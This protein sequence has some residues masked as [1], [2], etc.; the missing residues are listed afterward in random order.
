MTPGE[1]SKLVHDPDRLEQLSPQH[2]KMDLEGNPYRP[3]NIYLI[4]A[5]FNRAD[6]MIGDEIAVYDGERCVGISV[7]DKELN[8]NQPLQLIAHADDG[9]GSGFTDGDMMSY[10][11][12]RGSSGKE[13]VIDA[14]HVTYFDPVSGDRISGPGFASF[15][16]AVISFNVSSVSGVDDMIVPE[17]YYLYQN[18]PN[19][20]NPST[21]IKY[22][23]PV[24]SEV[25][26]E[27]YGVG[28]NFV[29]LI[30]QGNQAAGRHTVLWDGTNNRGIKVVSGVYF[31]K[32]TAGQFVD[33][34]K[35]ILAK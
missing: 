21:R 15:G 31:Y 9:S 2:F 35:M 19:P 4:G 18:H 34:K 8:R 7:L 29:K 11:V 3:M 17:E 27:L 22:N 20:F 33:T 28:G 25:K 5:Q 24:S 26:I 1:L 12:W 10:K 13:Q 16:T 6:L 14:A 32:L 23:L 30:Y